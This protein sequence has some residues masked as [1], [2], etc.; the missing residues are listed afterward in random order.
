[1]QFV[2][3][4]PNSLHL[5]SSNI[6][7]MQN[8]QHITP[9]SMTST[10]TSWR[11]QVGRTTTETSSCSKDARSNEL[12]AIVLTLLHDQDRVPDHADAHIHI[13]VR[14]IIA[15]IVVLVVEKEAEHAAEAEAEVTPNRAAERSKMLSPRL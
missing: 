1:M 4:I 9:M 10:D 5:P 12:D 7:A 6:Y 15:V 14:I 2:I 3:S 8:E 13:H 11:Q